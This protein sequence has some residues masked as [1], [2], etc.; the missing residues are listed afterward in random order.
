MLIGRGDQKPLSF[1]RIRPIP[2]LMPFRPEPFLAIFCQFWAKNGKNRLLAS[3]TAIFAAIEAK[4]G[5]WP[6]KL[7]KALPWPKRSFGHGN[8]GWGTQP[9]RALL[10]A[11]SRTRPAASL[12]PKIDEVGGDSWGCCV[13]K[14]PLLSERT[15]LLWCSRRDFVIYDGHHRRPGVKN[16][17]QKNCCE[18]FFWPNF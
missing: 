14:I 13:Q 1:G 8:V 9:G 11:L 2:P 18:R 12:R 7:A 3:I 16:S 5:P 10:S 17:C 15:G 4:A 6:A